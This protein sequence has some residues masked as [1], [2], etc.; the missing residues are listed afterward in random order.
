MKKQRRNSR[1]PVVGKFP[2]M[3]KV[4]GKLIDRTKY[5]PGMFTSPPP[6]APMPKVIAEA[7]EEQARWTGPNESAAGSGVPSSDETTSPFSFTIEPTE[8]TPN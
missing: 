6:D 8:T 1:K 4:G 3:L 2:R 7:M 5:V